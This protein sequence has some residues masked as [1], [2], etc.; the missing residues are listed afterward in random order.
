MARINLLPW[1]ELERRR[2]RRGLVAMV[3]AGLAATLI[4]GSALHLSLEGSISDQRSRNRFLRHEIGRL[5][6]QIRELQGLERTEERLLER[7]RVIR[8]LQQSRP[9]MVHLLDELA[10]RIPAGVHLTM[11]DQSG[12]TVV[13]EGRARSDALVSAFMRNI[14]DSEWIGKPSLIFIEHKDEADPAAGRFRLRFEQLSA[15][16]RHGGA[17]HEAGSPR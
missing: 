7:M 5:D 10:T 4:L 12:R 1:R 14:E 16:T 8:R 9:E 2:R 17:T 15:A 6:E 3:A 11:I 13:L